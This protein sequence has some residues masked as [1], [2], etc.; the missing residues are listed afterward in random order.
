MAD[1]EVS[2]DRGRALLRR[3]DRLRGQHVDAGQG[4]AARDAAE[5]GRP[6]QP[7]RCST[8][9]GSRS[10]SSATIQLPDRPDHRADRGRES[11]HGS[12]SPR[13]R[14]R[15]ATRSRSVAATA[16]STAPSSTASTR[17][18]IFSAAGRRFR[19]R[20]QVGG[21][22]NRYQIAFQEP[23]FLSRPYHRGLQLVPHRDVGF[24]QLEPAQHEH[25]AFGVILGKRLRR[26]SQH[27]PGLQ[28]AIGLVDSTHAHLTVDRNGVDNADHERHLRRT[29]SRASL[30]CTFPSTRSIIR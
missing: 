14:S 20:L 4:A 22:S 19:C 5:R 15:A 17:R 8:S 23:W 11:G 12:T 1:V 13:S 24:R 30:P 9:P 6:V 25:A 28:L 27:Q 29:R 7:Q 2:I 10:T 18:A 26:F 21:R 3:T 16:V